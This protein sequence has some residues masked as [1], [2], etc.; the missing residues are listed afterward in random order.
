MRKQ[1]AFFN[2]SFPCRTEKRVMGNV[3]DGF[4]LVLL[5]VWAGVY[6][7]WSKNF[8]WLQQTP[9]VTHRGSSVGHGAL[10]HDIYDFLSTKHMRPLRLF[11]SQLKQKWQI[12]T[13]SWAKRFKQQVPN[14]ILKTVNSTDYLM[15][16]EGVFFIL[17]DVECH[18]FS[19]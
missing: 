4:C 9:R 3:T 18:L 2:L 1:D 12:R 17:A 6:W 7:R 5:E 10:C 8:H 11:F 15:K 16:F 14:V 19:C 13:S